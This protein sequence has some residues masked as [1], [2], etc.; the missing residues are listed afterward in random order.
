MAI[1]AAGLTQGLMLRAFDE[2]GRLAYPDFVET[3]VRLIPMYWVRVLGG[4]LYIAGMVLCAWNVV[5]TWRRAP[6]TY[7][8]PVHEAPALLAGVPGRG[9]GRA[10]SS[11]R[12][13]T[14]AGRGCR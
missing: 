6:A 14:G 9:D 7:A 10:A 12:R 11:A 2:S 13:G 8:E 5:M 3:T 4:G 1:Y